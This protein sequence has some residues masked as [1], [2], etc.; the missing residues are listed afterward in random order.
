MKYFKKNNFVFYN[1]NPNQLIEND[2][3]TRAIALISGKDYEEVSEDLF[4]TSKLFKCER[5]CI[6]CYENLL[7]YVYKYQKIEEAIG[8]TIG[9]FAE[10]FP[11]GKYLTRV[12]GH[13]SAV[14]DGKIF[15]IWDCSNEI[16]TDCW[17]NC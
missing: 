15:D 11:N 7:N 2:C 10:K 12:N 14:C 3:V 5:L 1:N 4:R 17:V 13:L 8:L 6:C 9:E 16:I